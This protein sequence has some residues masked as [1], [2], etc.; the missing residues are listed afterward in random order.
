MTSAPSLSFEPTPSRIAF[1]LTL[2]IGALAVAGLWFSG[3]PS[4]A[5]W[6]GTAGAAA[7]TVLALHRLRRPL[8]SR[9]VLR[10]E[11]G[12]LIRVADADVA[13]HLQR[14]HDLG[15]LVALHFRT[16][17][18]RRIDVVIWPDAIPRGQRR[19]LRVWL[20]RTGRC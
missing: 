9:L 13:A 1:S 3:V 8:V 14:A 19:Q 7:A 4:T 2:T 18:G 20:G 15:F 11:G 17:A 5:Q 16:D 10:A 6:F 12:W